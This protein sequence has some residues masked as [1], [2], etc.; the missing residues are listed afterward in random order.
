MCADGLTTGVSVV[1]YRS[2]A[3]GGAGGWNVS[4]FVIITGLTTSKH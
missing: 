3:D 2:A 4:V 1:E